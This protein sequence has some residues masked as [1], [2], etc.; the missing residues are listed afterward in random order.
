[1]VSVTDFGLPPLGTQMAF[2]WMIGEVNR[3]PV[4]DPISNRSGEAMDSVSFTATASDPDANGLT[5]S[6]A[7][8][9][10]GVTIGNSGVISGV[11][12]QSGSFSVTVTVTD[13]GVPPLSDE[14]GFSW[15]LVSPPGFPIV[16][17]VAN[18]RS[19]T[20]DVV[21]LAP[22]GSHP[23]DLAL[24]WSAVNLPP[25]LGIDSRSGRITGIVEA[26]GLYQVVVSLIDSRD[27][28]VVASFN[29][30]VVEPDLPPVATTDTVRAALDALSGGSVAIDVIGNDHDPEG[31]AIRLV[32][33]GPAD[34]GAVRVVDGLVLFDPPN[35]WLGTESFPYVVADEGGNEAIGT[36]IVTIEQALG[37]R[38]AAAALQWDPA[39]PAAPDTS[40]IA[41]TSGAGTELLLGTVFQSLYV[42][43]VPL[44]LLGGA[45]F[46]SLLLGGILNLGFMFK[47]GMPNVVRRTSRHV[48]VVMVGH[49]EKLEVLD[50]PGSGR[51]IW[52]YTATERGLEATGRRS[53]ESDGTWAEIKT[54][55][56]H[57]WVPLPYLTEELDRAG[58]ADDPEPVGLVRDFVTLLRARRSFADLVSARGLAVAHHGPLLMFE[59]DMVGGLMEDD[60]VFVW[61]GRNPAYPD[62]RGTFDL[63]VATSIL[64]AWDHPQRELVHDEPTVPSTVVP[65]EFTNFHSISIGADVHGPERLDQSAWLVVFAQEGGRPRIVGLVKEG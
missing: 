24:T 43:R 38:I 32:S 18:Q 28:V 47:G 52:R 37:T 50:E 30:V 23:D 19:L 49:G 53:D 27:Q 4:I 22:R 61:K 31:T 51:A 8:L 12:T 46:W 65:V 33:A 41:L 39:A 26:A 36:V 25:G 9:P 1:V 63:A 59:R 58:F 62:H 15:T 54:P 11:P 3:P 7:G 48:A 13:K 14:T 21:S 20:G 57:G 29:W 16:G 64:D 34:I 35:G 55:N 40:S 17:S 60:T 42:L 45:V 44:A 10:A 2:D 5:F 6:A 56:G